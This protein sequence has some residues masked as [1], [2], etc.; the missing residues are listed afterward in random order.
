MKVEEI[1]INDYLMYKGDQIVQAKGIDLYGNGYVSFER[2]FYPI[3]SF[4]P[5]NLTDEI[6]ERIGFKKDAFTNLSPDYYYEDD[7]CSI[8]VNLNSTCDKCKSI[9]VENKQTRCSVSMEESRHSMNK[10]ILYL[11]DIQHAIIFSGL[12]NKIKL[13]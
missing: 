6:M 7:E 10:R 9:W 5:I 3:D 13:Q 11:H 4:S 12:N 2:E 1:M 8:C